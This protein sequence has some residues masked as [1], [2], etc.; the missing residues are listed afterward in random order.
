MDDPARRGASPAASGRVATRRCPDAALS[1][2]CDR[3]VGWPASE[4]GRS[5]GR[6]RP[7]SS[8]HRA[9]RPAG[10]ESRPSSPSQVAHIQKAW[11]GLERGFTSV[12]SVP[13]AASSS[14]GAGT[15][16]KRPK[17]ADTSRC[18]QEGGCQAAS[19]QATNSSATTFRP[20]P[21]EHPA[22]TSISVCM[23]KLGHVPKRSIWRTLVWRVADLARHTPSAPP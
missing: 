2:I 19:L 10:V 21:D 17:A 14:A 6:A 5:S 11:S 9:L 16:M 7:W 12:P 15:Q 3:V 4:D 22:L 1:A 13:N 18:H 8:A 20:V 23:Q